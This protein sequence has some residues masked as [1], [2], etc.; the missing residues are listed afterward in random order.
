MSKK[1]EFLIKWAKESDQL[2]SYLMNKWVVR[3]MN[4]FYPKDG[5]T[6]KGERKAIQNLVYHLNKMVA[7]KILHPSEY[8]G[9]GQGAKNDFFGT[10]IQYYW[11]V[12]ESWKE[13]QKL[14]K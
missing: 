3:W 12:R 7:E 5:G 6:T 8:T 13:K 4:T 14:I 10:K 11:K 1:R 2:T 9:L